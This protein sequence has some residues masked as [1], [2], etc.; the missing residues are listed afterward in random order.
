MPFQPGQPKPEGS[1]RQPNQ[2]NKITKQLKEM[3]LGA[4]DAEGGQEYLRTQAREQPAAFMTLLGKVLPT[5]IAGDPAAPL[6]TV[7]RI[8]MV[9]GERKNPST[10]DGSSA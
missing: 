3:I 10:A 9:P 6:Q 4:L 1:G 7:T 8:E 2:A 5:T